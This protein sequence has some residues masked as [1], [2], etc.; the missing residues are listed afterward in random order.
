M[1]RRKD[2]VVALVLALG[3]AVLHWKTS[4]PIAGLAVSAEHGAVHTFVQSFEGRFTDLMFRNRGARSPDPRVVILALDEQG[5]QRWGLWPWPRDVVATILDHLLDAGVKVV[6]LDVSFT[7]ESQV[8]RTAKEVLD[9]LH[10]APVPAALEPLEKVLSEKVAHDAD[11]KLEAVLVK[12][13]PRI[14]L[15][16]IP[17]MPQDRRSYSEGALARFD[18]DVKDQVITKSPGAVKGS[19][20]DLPVSLP[21][22]D[23]DSVMTPLARFAKAGALYGN[24]GA[25]VDVDGTIRR[26]PTL[27]KLAHPAGLFPSL[28]LRVAASQL[29]AVISPEVDDDELKAVNL[30]GAGGAVTRVPFQ[31]EVAF[32]L[33]NYPGRL[34]TFAHVS[35]TDAFENTP[36]F[37]D[38]V[39]GKAVLIG[40]TIVGSSGDQRVTPFEEL[41]PGVI[42]HA[43]LVSNIL[44][45]Q[46]LNRPAF[47]RPL[48]MALM[49]AFGLLLA[50]ALPRLGFR[51]KMM[52][53][54][55]VIS[56]WTVACAVAFRA[57]I[58]LAWVV[59]TIDLITTSFALIFMGYLT[60]D[61]EKAKMRNTFSRYLGEDVMDVALADP[62]KLNRGEK[63][64]MTVLF[65]D[66]RGF[67]S[68]SEHMAPERLMTFMNEY[69]TPMTKIV[70][71]E[72][73]TLDKY[74]GDA[75]MAFWNAP[76]DQPDHALRGCRAAVSMLERLD[77]LKKTWKAAG[78]PDLE[79]GIGVNTG[80]MVVGNMGSDV[81]VDYTVLGDA[82]NLGSRL[83]GTNKEYETRIVI[84]ESTWRAVKDQVVARR[85]G[86]VRVKGRKEPV[87]IFEL[88]AM[89]APSRTDALAIIAF[90]RAL[91]FWEQRAFSEAKAAFLEVVELW[92]TD[93]TT[94]LYL[95]A[96]ERYLVTPPPPNWDGVITMTTK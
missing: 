21:A 28:G 77:E 4:A 54:V 35:A 65:S 48:E 67:T 18:A 19:F 38:A 90:E 71:D 94:V 14:V 25:T 6:G 89:G 88:R 59:P 29:D 43:A 30:R 5:A 73:G 24:F 2:V 78:L 62:E 91:V 55:G 39:A 7:D 80:A 50:L 51:Y 57:G 75:V 93:R 8:D 23:V 52:L 63:R 53:V 42:T 85:L 66:I 33:I 22:Y 58:A 1:N 15:G 76:V 20:F 45:Q 70:F 64:E 60:V 36:A 41:T 11:A 34:S 87:R 81:R 27:V 68:L 47:T 86:A 31:D 92:P 3:F 32:T 61:R 16:V 83:E 49:I 56:G 44:N 96:V 37:R 46:F 10:A 79:I 72:K 84:S 26:V 17:I 82:V 40:V 9:A 12:G 74:I 13:G 95:A 69:L